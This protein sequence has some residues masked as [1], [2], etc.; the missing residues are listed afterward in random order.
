MLPTC[1]V[2]VFTLH[3]REYRLKH[4]ECTLLKL[5]L[6]IVPGGNAPGPRHQCNMHLMLVYVEYASYNK[7]ESHPLSQLTGFCT[8]TTEIK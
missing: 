7:A 2:F 8:K 5:V 3:A 6:K 1:S 4:F